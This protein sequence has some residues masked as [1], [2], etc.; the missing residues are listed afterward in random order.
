M[1][2]VIRYPGSKWGLADWI[3]SYFPAGYER[4]VYLEAFVGSGAVFFN[5]RAGAVETINDLDGDVVN[6][7]RVLREKPEELKRKLALTPYSREEY[8]RSFEACEDP[9]ERARRYMVRTTQ[10]I[11]AKMD[12]K[13]GWRN[14]KQM[15][16]GGTACKWAGIPN[17]IASAAE[18]LK[19]SPTNLVQIENMDALRLIERYNNRDV[20]MYLDPPYMRS[21]RRSGKLYRHEMDDGDHARL[22]GL[23]TQSKAQIV[24][25]GYS[26][27]QYDEALKGWN[28]FTAL[29]QTTSAEMAE[30][31]IWINYEPPYKQITFPEVSHERD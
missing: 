19:G 4:L 29:S 23:I 24:L 7:F 9:I 20:L 11:G 28:K 3:I 25:S 27:P 10:A 22:L 18:R 5:K 31:C 16:I 17:V 15:K 13:C 30:E 2:A 26:S 21:T 8:D 14:H 1:K 6:L 12:G